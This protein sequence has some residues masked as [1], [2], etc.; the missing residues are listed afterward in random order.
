MDFFDWSVHHKITVLVAALFILGVVLLWFFYPQS[1]CAKEKQGVFY[2][3]KALRTNNVNLCEKIVMNSDKEVCLAALHKDDSF[4]SADF[5]GRKDD[6]CVGLAKNDVNY[7]GTSSF[8]PAI[9][10]KDEKM[11]D[12]LPENLVDLELG[13]SD[14][15]LKEAIRECKAFATLDAEFF[16]SSEELQ[17]C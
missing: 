14:E 2:L 5:S 1:I 13:G 3:L 12:S 4:C 6:F 9:I 15:E 16:I 11:C 8:C 7:C 10:N 17:S